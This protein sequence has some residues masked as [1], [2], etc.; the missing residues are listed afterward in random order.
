MKKTIS[1]IT[2]LCLAL[3]I[4]YGFAYRSM[5][6]DNSFLPSVYI[7]LGT[8]K[9]KNERGFFSAD[10]IRY[11]REKTSAK[12]GEKIVV[13]FIL[14]GMDK[15]EYFQLA[16]SYNQSILKPGYYDEKG[17]WNYGNSVQDFDTI[18][19][20]CSSFGIQALDGSFSFTSEDYNP[21][22]YI[23]G[24]SSNGSIAIPE[25]KTFDN[26]Y[27]VTGAPL[28][29]VGF[30]VLS[31]IENIYDAFVW[32]TDSTVL[33][34]DSH[35]DEYTLN[36]NMTIECPHQYQHCITLPLCEESGYSCYSC[37]FCNYEYKYDFK[38]PIGHFYIVSDNSSNQMLNYI[39]TDCDSTDSKTKNELIEIWNKN[40]IN[41]V[42]RR[43]AVDDSCYTDTVY[44]GIINAKDFA[45]I[46]KMH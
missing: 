13:T 15:L 39:C 24:Y 42:P 38:E 25:S 8:F 34:S 37:T 5:A 33:C 9:N 29:S 28:V 30:D 3:T 4:Q 41:A 18:T 6:S 10:T 23:C 14:T 21:S 19:D 43:T 27:T 46:N 32:D 16:G 1:L 36:N 12:V 35:T 22:I 20:D 7:E 31:N 17:V 44:D 45:V 11:G 40:Y 26:G 2:A